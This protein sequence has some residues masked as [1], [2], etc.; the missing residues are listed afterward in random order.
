M[1]KSYLNDKIGLE[2]CAFNS[3][4]IFFAILTTRSALNN[5]VSETFGNYKLISIW[6]RSLWCPLQTV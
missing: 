6:C 3:T 2:A 5:Y 1:N 4:G